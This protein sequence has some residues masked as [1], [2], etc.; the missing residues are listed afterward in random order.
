[1]AAVG[2]N[3]FT[4]GSDFQYL[5]VNYNADCAEF[6]ADGNGFKAAFLTGFDQF[7]RRKVGGQIKVEP[8]HAGDGVANRTADKTQHAAV[9]LNHF[10]QVKDMGVGG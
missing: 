3:V 9:F 8:F 4:Q 1:M 6:D 2:F 7:V 10:K 5:I